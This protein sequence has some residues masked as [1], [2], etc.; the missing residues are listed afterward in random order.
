MF[1][2]LMLFEDHIGKCVVEVER[3][4]VSVTTTSSDPT[5]SIISVPATYNPCEI[6]QYSHSVILV[7]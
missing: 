2:L 7:T 4:M 6:E 1:A 5:W 3:A